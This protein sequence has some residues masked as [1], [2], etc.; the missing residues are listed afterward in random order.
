MNSEVPAASGECGPLVPPGAGA[1]PR[2]SAREWFWC[3][4]VSLLGLGLRIAYWRAASGSA[5]FDQAIGPDVAEYHDRACEILA[6]WW[7]PPGGGVD[8]HA[9]LYS[10]FLAAGYA[11]LGG[12]IPAV[13]LLQLLLNWGAWIG[14][15]PLLRRLPGLSRGAAWGAFLLAMILPVP[16]FHQGQLISESLLIPLLIG[17]L[18]CLRRG[19]ECSGSRKGAAWFGGAGVLSGAAAITHPMSLLFVAAETGYWLW[20]RRRATAGIFLAGAL[21]VIAPVSAVNS[22]RAG[23]LVPV[24]AN[25][26]FNFWLGNNP[27]ATG[28]CYVRSGEPWLRLHASAERRAEA[29]GCSPDRIWLGD[30][31]DFWLEEPVRGVLLWLRKAFL[32]W[33]PRELPSGSDPEFIQR[34]TSLVFLGG[35]LTLPLFLYALIG[36][37]VAIRRRIT[38]CCH[39]YL[40]GGAFYLAQVMTVTSGRYRLAMLPAVVVLAGIGIAAIDWRKWWGWLPPPFLLAGSFLMQLPTS[41]KYEAASLLG[42]AEFRRGNLEHA[43]DLLRFARKKLEDP[44]RFGNL[45][46]QIAWAQGDPAGAEQEFR[47]VLRLR[48]ENAAAAMNLAAL[49]ET[50]PARREECLELYR[51]AFEWN[52]DSSNLHFNYGRLLASSG[53]WKAAEPYFRRATELDPLHGPAW[54]ALGVAAMQRGASQEAVAAF[55]RAVATAPERREWLRNLMIACRAA[56]DIRRAAELERRLAGRNGR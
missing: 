28:G 51:K 36:V 8:I 11:L 10:W 45:L 44:G 40:L 6:G 21:L 56:G 50:D 17:A 4:A 31:L 26:A 13:R 3:G 52:P 22:F 32:V 49:L 2:M 15:L 23:R 1:S 41:G 55:E 25:S 29:A 27:R 39:L 19:E 43:A 24:Q 18:W 47:E 7:L 46:G 16:F 20:G 33:S 9:P 54:N 53:E 12:S 38:G 5:L 30:A 37:F 35:I 42:E 34:E 14:F 48:P